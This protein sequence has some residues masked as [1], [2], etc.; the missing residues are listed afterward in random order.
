MRIYEILNENTDNLS[1]LQDACE[2]WIEMWETDSAVK[3]ILS[4]PFTQNFKTANAST[5]YRS[6]FISEEKFKQQGKA[7]LTPTSGNFIPF[8][9]H[10]GW[11]GSVR[12]DF[13]YY[14]DIIQFKK[15][16]KASDLVLNFT[17]LVAGLFEKGYEIH[18]VDE[19][20]LWMKA[21]PYYTTFTKEEYIGIDHGDEN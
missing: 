16:F 20:E 8:T 15:A 14:G 12:D 21:T 3:E 5:I 19:A 1:E 9:V 11:G 2:N 18:S 13:D 6:V 4:H 17:A 10:S 7:I